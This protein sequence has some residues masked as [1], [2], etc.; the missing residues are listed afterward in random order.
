MTKIK[1]LD[2]SSMPEVQEIFKSVFMGEPW[3]DDWRDE[4]RLY[5]YLKDITGNPNSLS[6]GLFEDDK[7]VGFS[8][9]NIKHWYSGTEYCI[10][11]FCIKRENRI[12]AWVLCF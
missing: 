1:E 8:L 3:N 4:K 6:L 10:D 9:G 7:L 5:A 11:E 12:R 2:R